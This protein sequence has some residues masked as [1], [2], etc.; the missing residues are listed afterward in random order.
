MEKPYTKEK[1]GI[2]FILLIM[3]SCSM[4]DIR[5]NNIQRPGV[6]RIFYS[7]QKEAYTVQLA[8]DPDGSPFRPRINSGIPLL[9]P[10]KDRNQHLR[11]LLLPRRQDPPHSGRSP[12]PP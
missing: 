3:R 11:A 4:V 8:L 12:D 9:H 10:E 2:V 7:V 6:R 1:A 5:I